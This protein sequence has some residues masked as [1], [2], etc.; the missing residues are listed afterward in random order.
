[1]IRSLLVSAI[2]V[3]AFCNTASALNTR[4]WVSGKGVDQAGCGPVASPCRTLQYAHDNTT[5]GGQ[6]DVLDSA[7]YGALVI[8]R[9]ISIIADGSLAG[10]LAQPGADAI[11]I[12]AS[13]TDDVVLRGLFIDGAGAGRHGITFLGG[14]LKLQKCLIQNF[15]N[16]GLWIKDTTTSTSVIVE[17]VDIS[18]VGTA[19]Y[20]TTDNLQLNML[21]SR[22]LTGG[23]GI[24]LNT[25]ANSR[26]YISN[27]S[28]IRGYTGIFISGSDQMVLDGVTISGMGTGI[29]SNAGKL[30]IGRSTIT[31]SGTGLTVGSARTFFT[32][33][34]NQIS[35]NTTDIVGTAQSVALK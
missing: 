9:R 23:N 33:G 32:F 18:A 27:T 25:V 15:N 16:N 7:G 8:D 21:N 3:S 4:T 19:L 28:V 13:S 5:P 34:N 11:T 22:V 14:G 1:M 6:I 29:Q 12:S 30:L 31:G 17:D 2:A 26:F 24:Q 10:V 35:Q 20:S